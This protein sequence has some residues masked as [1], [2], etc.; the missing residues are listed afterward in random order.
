M[1]KEG[2]QNTKQRLRQRY[3]SDSMVRGREMI[4]LR[5]RGS[6][7]LYGCRRI[8]R[9]AKE[10]ICICLGKRTV[11]VYGRHLICTCFSAGSMTVEGVIDGVRY[12]Q[13]GEGVSG[14]SEVGGKA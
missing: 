1:T 3:G 5:G 13:N 14:S 12:L 4:V 9:Y 2:E 10:E 6:V 11:A 8:L 7:T